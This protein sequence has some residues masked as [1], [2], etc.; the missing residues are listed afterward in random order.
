MDH[1]EIILSGEKTDS[2]YFTFEL[3]D[4]TNANIFEN[5]DDYDQETIAQKVVLDD[6]N[7]RGETVKA[8][9]HSAVTFNKNVVLK[10]VKT[11]F[12]LQALD[13]YTVAYHRH[14]LERSERDMK[15]IST[16]GHWEYQVDIP[17][18]PS[19]FHIAETIH[20]RRAEMKE[21]QE[22]LVMQ[23]FTPLLINVTSVLQFSGSD[24]EVS[25]NQFVTMFKIFK[26]TTES[27]SLWLHGMF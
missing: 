4:K 8:T 25:D 2:C 3:I 17:V 24:C 10:H 9:N 16:N 7:T 15:R 12:Y 22:V 14:Q 13:D 5:E 23:R 27:M 19:T 1:C 21:V 20:I 18:L 6:D 11:G 26:E